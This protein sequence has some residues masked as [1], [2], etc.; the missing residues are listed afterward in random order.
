M[1]KGIGIFGKQYKIMYQNDTHADDSVDRILLEEMIKLD[2]NSVEYLYNS[3]TDL[4]VRYKSGSR[5]I[6]ENIASGLKGSSY[7]ETVDNIIA[8]CRNIVE[9]CEIDTEDFV[10]GGTEEEIIERGTYWCTDIARVACI[11]FQIVGLPSRIIVTANTKLA[12]SGHNVTEVYYNNKWGITDPTNG[13]IARHLDG[14]PISAWEIHN[15]LI[16]EQYESVGISN[17]Y[18]DEKENYKYDISKVNDYYREILKH[19]SEQWVD[20]LRWIHGE[21]L[22]K[23]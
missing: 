16:D 23:I 8:Y 12:Y 21:D 3:Y 4:H 13:T 6:L 19:S 20:G 11:M 1:E 5:V 9:N 22:R 2:S 18:V 15:N 7:A 14:T 10:F 17:Y